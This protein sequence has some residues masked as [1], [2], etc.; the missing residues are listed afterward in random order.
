MKEGLLSVEYHY[1]SDQNINK[2]TRVWLTSNE[3]SWNPKIFENEENV[4]ITSFWD[5]IYEFQ[6]AINSILVNEEE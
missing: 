4:T 3:Q 2:L 6:E 5:G 1:P